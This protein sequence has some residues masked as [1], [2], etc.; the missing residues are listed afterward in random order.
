MRQI[1]LHL[2]HCVELLAVANQAKVTKR[3]SNTPAT[4]AV[5]PLAMREQ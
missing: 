1:S 5:P 4:L 2:R 3:P